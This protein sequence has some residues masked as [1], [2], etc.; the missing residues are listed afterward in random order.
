MVAG[1]LAPALQLG[2][3]PLGKALGHDAVDDEGHR[4][5]GREKVERT[6]ARRQQREDIPVELLAVANARARLPT[7]L[8]SQVSTL[9]T[10]V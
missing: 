8:A 5:Q 4:V 2:Q 3:K 1:L 10:R 6:A 9:V 7:W